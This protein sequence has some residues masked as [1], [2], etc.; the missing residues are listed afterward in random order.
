MQQI[1]SDAKQL[2]GANL[3]CRYSDVL[4]RASALAHSLTNGTNAASGQ[5]AVCCA[6][7]GSAGTETL[8]TLLQSR[9]DHFTCVIR[10]TSAGQY[11]ERIAI[12]APPNRHYVEAT[13]GT[14]LAGGIAVPLCLSHP[15]RCM[16]A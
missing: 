9:C 1:C 13:W 7:P 11:G 12:M 8:G 15:D 6:A 4:T 3:A 10:K 5:H 16:P 2:I 14:W